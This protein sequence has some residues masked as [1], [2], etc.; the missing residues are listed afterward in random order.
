[1]PLYRIFSVLL[2][3]FI[4]LSALGYSGYARAESM[5]RAVEAALNY[6]PS[7]HAALANRDAS[8]YERAEKVSD[9]F[10]QVN[11]RAAGGRIFGDNSTTRGL[12][13]SRGEGYSYLWEGSFTLTQPIFN[14]FETVNRLDAATARRESAGFNVVDIRE[15]LALRTTLV[16]LDVLKGKQSLQKLN[17]HLELI[18]DYRN[19]IREMVDGGAADEAMAVQARDIQVQLE[20]TIANMEGQLAM[21]SAEYL[22]LT[23]QAPSE[24]MPIPSLDVGAIP[25]DVE[26]A[27]LK[28]KDNHPMLHAALME[29]RAMEFDADAEEGPLYP[30]LSGE[31][32]YLERDQDDVIGGEVK[33]ARA[34]VRMNWNFSLGGKEIHRMKGM[35]KRHFESKAKRKEIERSLEKEIRAAWAEMETAQNRLVLLSERVRLNRDLLDTNKTQFEGARVNLLQLMQTD[36]TLFNARMALLNGEYRFMASRYSTLANI[37]R[38]QDALGVI[39]AS[40]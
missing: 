22:E 4:A 32:S 28:G 12:S 40:D 25:I 5:E 9:F 37:G 18:S 35:Q 36:N 8:R 7:V 6:H 26:E 30:D 31:L 3:S 38:L 27:V 39:P 19:R 13:V 14:G 2:V 34:L 17:K 15:G 10:P 1:M 21:A 29:E 33:D 23:G 11:A 16:Y 24:P 20:N